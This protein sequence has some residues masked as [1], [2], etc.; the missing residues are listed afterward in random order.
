MTSRRTRRRVRPLVAGLALVAALLPPQ[1]HPPLVAAS[2]TWTEIRG[3][4]FTLVGRSSP[5]RLGNL[6]CDLERVAAALRPLR[7]ALTPFTT[8]VVIA[9]AGE[10]DMRELLPQFWE[11]RGARPVGGY[12]A[13]AFGHHLAIRIDAPPR[14]RFRRLLH[15]YA[16]FV[17]HLAAPTP[18][19]WLDEGLSELWT[20]AALEPAGV[21]LGRPVTVHLGVLRSDARWIPVRELTAAKK[22]PEPQDR[23][24]LESFYAGSWA[25]VHYL[26]AGQARGLLTPRALAAAA[27]PTDAELRAYLRARPLPTLMI[28]ASGAAAACA[29]TTGRRISEAESDSLRARALA[30]GGHPEAAAPLVHRILGREAGN[31]AALEVLGLADF[32]ENRPVSAAEAFDRVIAAGKASHVA[33]YYRAVLAQVPGRQPPGAGVPVADYLNRALRLTPDFLPARERLRELEGRP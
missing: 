16:H 25:L 23:R 28:P 7:P 30:D 9:A 22:L 26:V 5:E 6:A 29:A 19:P 11:Q 3:T 14:E 1:S 18:P 2:D 10:R 8:P 32:L 17:T 24:R 33:Y 20:H 21:V 15:E 13:G 31:A 4:D 27:M 12:W